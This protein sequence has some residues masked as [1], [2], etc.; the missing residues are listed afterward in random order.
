MYSEL[1]EPLLS[2][3]RRA[4]PS[5]LG[6]R[7]ALGR[8]S[9]LNRAARGAKVK[10]VAPRAKFGRFSQFRLRSKV[11]LRVDIGELALW[12]ALAWRSAAREVAELVP[13]IIT[14]VVV[15]DLGTR[16]QAAM[17]VAENWGCAPAKRALDAWAPGDAVSRDSP[18]R[19]LSYFFM[20]VSWEVRRRSRQPDSPEALLP[21]APSL[22]PNPRR[23]AARRPCWC[24]RR[25]A[26]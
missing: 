11:K 24:R 4:L 26:R 12:W 25:T 23:A 10:A 2:Q 21:L 17:A 8:S 1:D 7:A 14:L 5:G 16:P 15:G 3:P 18:A 13:W 22:M 19:S 20:D 9:S 6:G